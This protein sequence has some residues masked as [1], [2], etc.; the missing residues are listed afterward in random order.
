MTLVYLFALQDVTNTWIFGTYLCKVVVFIQVIHI[1]VFARSS[2]GGY[3]FFDTNFL[4]VYQVQILRACNL[5]LSSFILQA[6]ELN[7][8][9][10]YLRNWVNKQ[11]SK[12][13]K[14]WRFFQL[15]KGVYMVC[16]LVYSSTKVAHISS[17]VSKVIHFTSICLFFRD[18]LG[19]YFF[20]PPQK[21]K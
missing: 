21:R 14:R 12:I 8:T 19:F 1:F 17:N 7:I 13:I 11:V 2:R 9:K 3:L 15:I 6:V 5:N 10:V 20:I 16:F 4:C 18:N